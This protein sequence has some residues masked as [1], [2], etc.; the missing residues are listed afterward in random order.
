[1]IAEEIIFWHFNN[2][3]D[4][5]G[6]FDKHQSIAENFLG[7]DPP[8]LIELQSKLS[9]IVKGIYKDDPYFQLDYVN[10][11]YPRNLDILR[12]FYRLK[13]ESLELISREIDKFTEFG[14]KAFDEQIEIILAG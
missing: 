5:V 6:F 7:F 8:T 12:P 3:Y 13:R 1:L 11:Q 10:D 2:F 4:P 9:D 14:G